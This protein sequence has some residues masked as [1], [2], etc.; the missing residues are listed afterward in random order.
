MKEVTN[1]TRRVQTLSDGTILAASGTAG[2]TKSIAALS[3]GDQKRLVNSGAIS[4]RDKSPLKAVQSPK[5]KVQSPEAP[6]SPAAAQ[7]ANAQPQAEGDS[8]K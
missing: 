3:D 5:P 1:N 8:K 4:V 2:A 7:A 6:A